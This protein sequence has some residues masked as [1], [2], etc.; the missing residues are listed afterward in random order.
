M[1][2][3]ARLSVILGLAALA[4]VGCGANSPATSAAAEFVYVANTKSNEISQ[5]SVSAS[6][7][8]ALTPLTPS[9]VP[10]GQFPYGMAINQAGNSVYVANV[11]SSEVSQYTINPTTGQLT[12]KTPPAVAAGPG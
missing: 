5:Y 10:T 2:R 1:R 7:I 12:P 11:T 6:G 8:G 9:T 3:Q 4:L